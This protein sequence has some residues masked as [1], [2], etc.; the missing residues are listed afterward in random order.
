[1]K[2]KTYK[3]QYVKAL[4][5]VVAFFLLSN[6]MTV[7]QTIDTD[8]RNRNLKLL[9]HVNERLELIKQT[10]KDP[11]NIFKELSDTGKILKEIAPSFHQEIINSLESGDVLYGAQ[12]TYLNR[13]SALFV[14]IDYQLKKI[15]QSQNDLISAL[16]SLERYHNAYIIYLKFYRNKQFRRLVNAEDQSYSIERKQVKR[17]ISKLIQRKKL[18]E[19]RLK[20]EKHLNR[21]KRHPAFNLIYDKSYWRK[22]R[23]ALKGQTLIDFG[24]SIKE[25]FVHNASG[26]FG[27]SMGAIRWRKGWMWEDHATREHIKSL[28]KPLDIITEKVGYTPTD[29]FIPGHFGHNAIWLGTEEDLKK[30]GIWNNEIIKPFQKQIQNGLNIIETDRSGTHL[31]SLRNFMNVDQFAILRFRSHHLDLN[32]KK[33]IKTIYEV[34][35]S[36]LGKSYDFNFDVETTDQLVCSE[37]LYQSFGAINWPTEDYLGRTTISPDNVVSLA[38]Y[39]DSP[40]ELVYYSESNKTGHIQLKDLDDLAAD[41]GFVKSGHNYKVVKKKCHYEDRKTAARERGFIKTRVCKKHLDDLIYTPHPRV[42]Y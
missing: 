25:E 7:A 30:L 27:N 32:E 26:I 36:Q 35:L 4:M 39:D 22:W 23:M 31:K 37:L 40:L 42:N 2:T 38:L 18:R 5:I 29:F 15:A 8:F 33:G 6:I 11:I 21:S 3:N 19:T 12:L 14:S 13:I 28:L 17:Q 1:M 10:K 41:I 20:A 9:D 16:A 34:A 24:N